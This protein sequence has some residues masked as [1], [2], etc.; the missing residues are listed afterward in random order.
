MEL[1]LNNSMC[2]DLKGLRWLV[3]RLNVLRGY[4]YPSDYSDCQAYSELVQLCRR[5]A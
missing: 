2:S 1:F 3:E 4:I 5:E